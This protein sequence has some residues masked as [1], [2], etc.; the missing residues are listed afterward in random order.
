M[1][2][3]VAGTTVLKGDQCGRYGANLAL[4][5]FTVFLLKI[6]ECKLGL[7]Q[8]CGYTYFFSAVS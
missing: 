3:V 1:D 2:A 4:S 8:L 7:L 6:K 5:P